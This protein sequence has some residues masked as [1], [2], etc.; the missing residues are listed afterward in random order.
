VLF[1]DKCPQTVNFPGMDVD[2]L[3]P[4][5]VTDPLIALQRQ[6]L[7]PLSVE[8]LSARIASLEAEIARIKAKI[9]SAVN[10]RASAESLFKR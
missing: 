9:D 5:G 8:E 3:F 2:D 7:D 6:D 4:K 10:H 1:I